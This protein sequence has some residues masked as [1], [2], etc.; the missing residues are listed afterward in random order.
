MKAIV[1]LMDTL[2]RDHL[3]VYHPQT[4]VKSDNI[5]AFAQD[6]LIFD[7]HFVGSMPCMPAR[8]DL[9]TGRLNFLERSW[10]P[11]EIFDKTL[12]AEL[13]KKNIPSHMIT[14]HA[15]YFRIGGE[16]YCQ[17]FDTYE[18]FRGQESDPWISM[19]DDP[20]MPETWFGEVKRQYQCNRTMFKAETDYPSVKCFASACDWLEHNKNAKDFL[21]MVETFDPHEPFDIPK[22]YLDIYQDKYQGPHFD[23]PK[24]HVRDE[25]TDEAMTHIHNRYSALITMTDTHFGKL[26]D[27]L[28]ALDM[29]DDTLII[30]TT[31]HGYC[32][33]EREFIGKSYMHSFNELANI[34]LIVHLPQ[35]RLAGA[36]YQE[37]TQNID[38]MPTLLR[39]FGAETPPEVNGKSLFNII[40]GGQP[41]H[42]YVIYGT[43]GATV[44]ICDGRYTYF[45]APRDNSQCYEYTTSLT[46]IRSWLG[47]AIPEKIETGHFLPR[48]PFPVYKVPAVLNPIVP[49][50]RY[51]N[52]DALFDIQEDYGQRKNI[53]DP[54]LTEQMI[55]LLKTALQHHDAPPEQRLRLGLH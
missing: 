21:L 38:I 14:D 11:I 39:Y 31:D 13:R 35:H 41:N 49:D 5:A 42:P 34:P 17:Q 44:N 26:I 40:D 28:K 10:G 6:S 29:Y 16:N 52:Q 51:L 8:R 23:L 36:R 2:R 3:S 20:V 7:N 9:F 19:V 33:G 4:R 32:F 55:G 37:L 54:E 45:R 15:H 25:E 27:K 22:K 50:L 12:P 18:F 30:L 53:T 1:V 47:K 46:T 48:Q 43:H 24:Y